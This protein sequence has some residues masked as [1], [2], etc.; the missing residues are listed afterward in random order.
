MR[1]VVEILKEQKNSTS[2]S[3]NN[4]SN[5]E[6]EEDIAFTAQPMGY[7][8]EP[9]YTD[10]DLRQMDIERAERER[11]A[12]EA[13]PTVRERENVTWW[14]SCTECAPMPKE[15]ESHCCREWDLAVPLLLEMQDLSVSGEQDSQ[16]S[17]PSCCIV[18]HPNFPAIVNPGVL[19]TFFHIPKINWKERPEPAGAD[20]QLSVE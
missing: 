18:K 13:G 16:S 2:D 14:C 12:R 11:R 1:D 20:G 9:E 6:G 5:N 15:V 3:S 4:E 17:A 8:Y 7:L 19:Q 10:E